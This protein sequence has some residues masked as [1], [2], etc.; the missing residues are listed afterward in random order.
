MADY[1]VTLDLNANQRAEIERRA[2]E[3]GYKSVA[4]YL[5]ALA[6]A[7]AFVEAF[8]QDWQEADEDTDLLEAEFRQAWHDVMTGNVR[9]ISELWDALEEDDDGQSAG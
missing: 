4:D 6:V 8:R 5:Q 1:L 2:T 7:D 3:Q 9:P